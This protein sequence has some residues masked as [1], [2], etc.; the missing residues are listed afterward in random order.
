MFLK[1]FIHSLVL[2]LLIV[3]PQ[4]LAQNVFIN[5]L[6]VLNVSSHQDEDGDYNGWFEL[7]NASDFPIDLSGYTI[8][9]SNTAPSEW[10]IDEGLLNP[11]GYLVIFNSGKDRKQQISHW[12]AVISRGDE[13]KYSPGS[14][15]I[16]LNW[17]EL[18]FD[19]TGW[20]TGA[21]GFGYGD[22]DDATVVESTISLYI[23]KVFNVQDLSQIITGVLHV[24]YDDGFVAYLNGIEIARENIGIPGERPVYTEPAKEIVEAR[25]YQ[26]GSPLIF[27]IESIADILL[28]GTN[29]L[30][31]ETHNRNEF[32]T[33]LTIIP[34]LSLAMKQRPGD[35]R[36]VDTILTNFPSGLHTDFTFAQFTDT[37]YIKSPDGITQDILGFKYVPEDKS[38]GRKPDGNSRNYR[39][40][41]PTP[42]FSNNVGTMDSVKLE[43]SNLPVVVVDTYGKLI[44]DAEKISAK[45]GI[46]YN[47]EG[48]RNY[49]TDPFNN[50]DGSIGIETRGASSQSYPKKQYAL[51]TR[52]PSGENNN[53]SLLGLPEEN[54]WILHAPYV[55]K[56]LMRNVLEYKLARDLGWYA[57]RT[58]YCELV[59]NGEYQGV[60]ILME[61]IKRDKNRVNIAKLDPD[62]ISGEEVT[63]GYIIKLDK[64]VGEDV[65]GWPSSFPPK[66]YTKLFFQYHYPK[67][68][69]IV[70]EQRVYIQNF[71][72]NFEEALY[73]D[74]FRDPI[75]GYSPL[76]NT[77]SFIDFFILVEIGRNVDG[78]R[79]ST[80]MYKD[81]DSK[82]GR[83]T[84]GPVW[85][86]NLAFGNANY[87]NAQY[88]EGW[89]KDWYDPDHT[90]IPFW[91]DRL[92][93]DD[94]FSSKLAERWQELRSTHLH[95]IN[96]LGI[97][98][99]LYSVLGE[100]QE[101]NFRRWPVLGTRDWPNAYVGNTYEDEVAYLE[102]WLFERL[103]WMDENIP[104]ITGLSDNNNSSK[105]PQ[106]FVLDQNYP[107][108]FNPITTINYE[109]PITNYV[110]LSV[111]NLL[112]QKVAVLVNKYQPAGTY[113]MEWDAS[114][115]GSGVYFY[116]LQSESGYVQ[117]RK[118]VLLK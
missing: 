48:I 49:F 39:F 53:V 88:T 60:Y 67:P 56:S 112:G 84:M 3:Q 4:L 65:G 40:W 62:E 93:S 108:P 59:L 24:D 69:D 30:A 15:D 76:I 98:D 34:Y 33:D 80:F 106:K 100:A 96:I 116:R 90:D 8:S 13:W 118:M 113:Q 26:N 83:L 41:D 89:Q 38:W 92:L 11:K 2:I 94:T 104:G 31:I 6:M 23:R 95:E 117:V 74:S 114:G 99:S 16:P 9:S 32:S 51:E 107:N 17:T 1:Y 75:S 85:D 103:R 35:S 20:Q 57:S 29:V 22:N 102:E 64:T 87:D 71:I 111:Y 12:E 42:G 79:L 28:E 58:H 27:Q 78:Y 105:I 5:E 63:G 7:Y 77:K 50:Y 91:W 86:Y 21:S 45:M 14:A 36:Q 44:P 46:I 43:A 81:R 72:Y 109:L 18:E 68:S 37:L 70:P 66:N 115:F 25:I 61:K 73:S 97:L 52:L 82:D 54:D 110:D 10:T 101:R 55:D 19:D 47:G